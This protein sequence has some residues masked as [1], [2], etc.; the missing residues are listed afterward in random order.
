[1]SNTTSDRAVSC[2]LKLGT[3]FSAA[4]Y[5]IQVFF[6]HHSSPFNLQSK[7]WDRKLEQKPFWR[8]VALE[9]RV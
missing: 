7:F 9:C 8:Y 4:E 5:F 6:G 3:I 1:M 2:A